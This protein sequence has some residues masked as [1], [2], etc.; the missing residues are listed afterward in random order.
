MRASAR[1]ANVSMALYLMVGFVFVLDTMPI[2]PSGR[3]VGVRRRL[4]VV[5]LRGLVARS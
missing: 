1:P 4:A 3:V 5:G 2:D